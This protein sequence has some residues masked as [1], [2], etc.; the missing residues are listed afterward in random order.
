MTSSQSWEKLT[1]NGNFGNIVTPTALNA[2]IR[3]LQ[4]KK[5]V[6]GDPDLEIWLTPSIE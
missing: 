2:V 5:H 4:K 3:R 1:S 6:A